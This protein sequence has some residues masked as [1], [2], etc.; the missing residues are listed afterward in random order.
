[1]TTASRRLVAPSQVPVPDRPRR[2]LVFDMEGN[3]FAIVAEGWLPQPDGMEE[4]VWVRWRR[5][6]PS[7]NAAEVKRYLEAQVRPGDTVLRETSFYCWLPAG[8]EARVI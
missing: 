3:G 8:L 4:Q 2:H 5:R 7:L 6:T 1:M